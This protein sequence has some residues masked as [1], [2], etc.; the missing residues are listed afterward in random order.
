[1]KI[2]SL[3]IVPVIVLFLL[4]FS[5]N[6]FATAQ[7]PDYLVYKGETFPIFSNPLE[8]YF[9]AKNPL[10][11]NVFIFSC[12]ASWRGYVATWKIEDR[13]LYLTKIVEGTCG[14][15]AKEIPISKIF[16]EQKA[17]IK[18]VWFSGTIR[19]PQ[20]KLLSYVHMGYGSVYEK[21]L[22]LTIE[23]GK[24]I[25]EDI[26]DNTQKALPSKEKRTLDELGKLKK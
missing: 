22:L 13:Y 16:P 1:M 10:P 2:T 3:Y 26:V 15:D 24:L 18:A 11:N 25:K 23:D 8:S 7:I 19:I 9:N 6:A 5:V 14:M 12:T 4:I 21:E 17:P 20:G